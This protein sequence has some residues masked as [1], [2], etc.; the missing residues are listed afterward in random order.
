MCN[1]FDRRIKLEQAVRT[2]SSIFFYGDFKPETPNERKLLALLEDLDVWPE[3]ED[4]LIEIV[5][6]YS[7]D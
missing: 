7:G 2:V 6:E 3:D 1:T 4:H 5:D